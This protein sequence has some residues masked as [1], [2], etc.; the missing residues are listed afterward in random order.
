MPKGEILPDNQFYS[1]QLILSDK[2]EKMRRKLDEKV[3]LDTITLEEDIYL[4]SPLMIVS[5]YF[6]EF[7]IFSLDRDFRVVMNMLAGRLHK[8]FD[9]AIREARKHCQNLSPDYF[10]WMAVQGEIN[11]VMNLV[12]CSPILKDGRPIIYACYTAAGETLVR[13]TEWTGMEGSPS[14]ELRNL[15]RGDDGTNS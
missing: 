12:G 6:D 14:S 9:T 10:Q 1:W 4:F 11:G 13:S 8:E 2:G 7:G 3:G 5:G 15:I